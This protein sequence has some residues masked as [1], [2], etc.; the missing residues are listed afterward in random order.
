MNK[1]IYWVLAIA[2]SCGNSRACEGDAAQ[3]SRDYLTL[4]TT[5]G[6]FDGGA[7]VADVDRW[8]G[9]KHQLMQCLAVEFSTPGM[10]MERLVERM[11]SPD[12]RERCK[13]GHCEV[14]AYHWRGF[15]DRLLFTVVDGKVTRVDWDYAYE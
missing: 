2:F 14:W 5:R 1:V 11:G 9:R 8:N 12:S 10:A 13:P 6:H 15:H 4:R 3:W 7:W